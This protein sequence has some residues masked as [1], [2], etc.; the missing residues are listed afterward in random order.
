MGACT[1]AMEMRNR[2]MNRLAAGIALISLG[3]SV[4][5]RALVRDIHGHSVSCNDFQEFGNALTADDQ[6]YFSG[7]TDRDYND[8]AEWIADCYSGLLQRRARLNALALLQ[9]RIDEY[10]RRDEEEQK[11]RATL[12]LGAINRAN[13]T[14]SCRK[15]PQSALYLAQERIIRDVQ[16]IAVATADLSRQKRIGEVSG[17]VDLLAEHRDGQQIVDFEDDL[18]S[19]WADYKKLGGRAANPQSVA[20]AL[21]DPCA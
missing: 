14:A 1:L 9:T 12:E 19:V 21:A 20:H 11:R 16:S 4:T 6:T 8:A 5:T 13:Q 18:T 2:K 7:W 10:H 3:F 15:S 17:A